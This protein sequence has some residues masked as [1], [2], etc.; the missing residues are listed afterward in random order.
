MHWWRIRRGSGSGWRGLAWL[1]GRRG[2]RRRRVT[3]SSLRAGF[4]R[5][6][7]GWLIWMIVWGLLGRNSW[8]LSTSRG[9]IWMWIGR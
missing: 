2:P 3:C 9:T 6:T 5:F 7:R 8:G 4:R 1:P